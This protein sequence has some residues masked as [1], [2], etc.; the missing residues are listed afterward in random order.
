M[1]VSSTPNTYIQLI[2]MQKAP[3]FNNSNISP[4]YRT[5]MYRL[6]Q[7]KVT[8]VGELYASVPKPKYPK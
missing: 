1:D 7:A 8:F 6:E 5:S 3:V 4:I 2:C